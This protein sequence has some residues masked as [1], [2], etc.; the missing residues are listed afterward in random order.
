[1]EPPRRARVTRSE[2]GGSRWEVATRELPAG[3]RPHV[4]ELLGYGEASVLPRVQRQFPLPQVV[5]II[6]FGPPIRVHDGAGVPSRYAGGFVA[7]LSDAWSDTG[8]DGAQA[9][10]Q[11]NLTPIGARLVF[12]VALSELT[13][14]IVHLDDLLPPTHRGLA[15]RLAACADW[16]DRFDMVESFI[17][18]RLAA[19]RVAVDT[20]AWACQRIE[21]S[22]GAVD[23]GRLA[24]EL[25]YSSKHLVALF[26][27]RVG[28]P[29]KL[30]ARLVRFDRLIHRLKTGPASTW[31]ALAAEFGF[32]DQAHLTR[33]VRGFTGVTPT[34]VRALLGELVI[35]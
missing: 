22:A 32:A 26:R 17:A 33:E 28:V 31:A 12:G 1:M 2:A 14:H 24:G 18:A 27:D 15:A 10:M 11:L 25:G 5:V 7:G 35:A 34:G 13:G 30:L 21:A 19:A 8:H 20:V 29:P 16:D 9:G 23:I 4:R 3:L 6:E